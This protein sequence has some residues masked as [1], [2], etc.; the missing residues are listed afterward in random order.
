MANLKDIRRR[1]TSVKNTQK[2]TR[3][4]KLVAAAKFARASAAVVSSR[5][6]GQ[7]FDQMVANLV[8]AS[9]GEL[10][11]PLVED[12]GDKKN[13]LVVLST[14]RGF[15]GGLNANLLKRA[16]KFIKDKTDSGSDVK[17]IAWGRRAGSFLKKRG[18]D[19]VESIEKVLEKVDYAE[20]KKLADQLIEKFLS[21][22][23]DKISIAFMKFQSAISQEPTIKQLLPVGKVGGEAQANDAD[24]LNMVVEP[25]AK[26]V[27]ESLLKKVVA[28][29]IFRCMLEG[30]ASEHGARM[31]AMDAATGNADEVVRKLTIEYNRARQAAITN[32]LIEICCGASAL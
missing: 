23:C 2:I 17:S 9:G 3:A 25:D 12:R 29:A 7:A 26:Q 19:H 16:A 4:M 15:C 6:Y 20:A 21:G 28:S 27:L 22:E 10:N 14:D 1:I 31:A 32:E 8:A 18:P 13:L 24:A 30:A 5:P 11:S